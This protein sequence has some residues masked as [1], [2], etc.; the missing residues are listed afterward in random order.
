MNKQDNNGGFIVNRSD[1]VNADLFEEYVKNDAYPADDS[2][3]LDGVK[4]A[5]DLDDSGFNKKYS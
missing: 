2:L 1:I 5:D 3:G 4:R